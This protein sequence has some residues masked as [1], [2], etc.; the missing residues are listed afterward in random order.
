ME[1]GRRRLLAPLVAL[2][3]AGM[4]FAL[5]AVNLL[6]LGGIHSSRGWL[7]RGRQVQALLSRAR[8]E[9]LEAETGQRGYLLTG[10]VDYLEPLESAEVSLPADLIELKRLTAGDP[11]QQRG[12]AAL[13][14]LVSKKREELR[15]TIALYQH[16]EPAAALAIVRS[17]DGR[18]T[19]D[20]VRR[21]TADM[22]A[23]AETLLD[24]RTA[25]A[26]RNF[27]RAMWIDVGAGLCI[28]VLGSILFRINRDIAR[29]EELERALREAAHSQEQFV[30]IL[31]HDLRNPL[32]AIV[33]ATNR[34][35][36]GDL[37]ETQS[38]AIARITSSTTRMWRM[39]DQL[40]DL[41]QARLSDGIPITPKP[42]TDLCAVVTSTV[43]ELRTAYPAAEL[44]VEMSGQ[45]LGLWDPD[46]MAQVVSNVVAN[47][48]HYGVGPVEVRVRTADGTAMLEVHNGGPPIPEDLLPHVFEAFHR[49]PQ[50]GTT[51]SRGLGLGLF[52]AE[53]IVG[54]HGGRIDVRSADREGT[55]FSISLPAL[56]GAPEA[57]SDAVLLRM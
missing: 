36:R 6:I 46:R 48:I 13:E 34:L 43:D 19:M 49:R 33:M 41:T 20:D 30:G 22:R 27:D 39:I 1:P 31:G 23:R 40:L 38:S 21:V 4:L 53:R 52:I 42:E 17:S 3:A 28:L 9:L 25:K 15:K 35:E 37:P 10:Q 18:A 2:L 29:R 55:T 44:V 16:G 24:E 47:A 32:S 54:A 8:A 12:A 5:F 7:A 14:L 57:S 11:A 45:V 26:R 51:S 50:D 56:G